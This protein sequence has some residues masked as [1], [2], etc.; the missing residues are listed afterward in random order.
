[1]AYDDQFQHQLAATAKARPQSR[2]P[3]REPSCDELQ[4]IQEDLKGQ[5]SQVDKVLRTDSPIV[6]HREQAIHGLAQIRIELGYRDDP[7][8]K[9][10]KRRH[11]CVPTRHHCFR[12]SSARKALLPAHAVVKCPQCP[13]A[14]P[15]CSCDVRVAALGRGMIRIPPNLSVK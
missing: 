1:M 14:G 10:K 15:L 4:A 13:K 9:S 5:I 7:G 6:V 11:L 8:L 12:R 2:N 3:S